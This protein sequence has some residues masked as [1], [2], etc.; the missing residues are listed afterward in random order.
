MSKPIARVL[1]WGAVAAGL[2]LCAG[3]LAQATLTRDP[4]GQ[5]ALQALLNQGFEVK[6]ASLGGSGV[7]TLYLQKSS[8]LYACP[9]DVDGLA[10]SRI[11]SR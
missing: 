11:L 1:S 5:V 3:A 9:L 6:A 8:L 4:G 10:C 7:Q 2:A